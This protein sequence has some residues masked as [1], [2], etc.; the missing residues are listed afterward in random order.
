MTALPL[1]LLAMTFEEIDF[2]KQQAIRSSVE[3]LNNTNGK[4]GRKRKSA[5]IAR[6]T[7]GAVAA[8]MMMA[9]VV[10]NSGGGGDHLH[11]SSSAAAA[12]SSSSASVGGGMG[13]TTTSTTSELRTGRWTDEETEYCDALIVLFELGKLPIPDGIKLN[14]FLANM[15]K[16]KQSRLTKKMKN[17]R[18]STK[19][20]QRTTGHIADANEAMT[21]S[22]IETKFVASIKCPMERA[23]IRFHMQK[24]WREHFS[25]Y[26]V[27]V[28]QPL[29][30]NAW[31]SSVEELDRRASVQKDTERTVRR[32][33][34]MGH[35]LHFDATNCHSR[36]VYIEGGQ[37]QQQEPLKTTREDHNPMQ[38][39]AAPFIAKVLEIMK[40]HHFPFEHVDAWVPSFLQ[41]GGDQQGNGTGD[42][43]SNNNNSAAAPCRLCFAGCGTTKYKVQPGNQGAAAGMVKLGDDEEFHLL[44][45]GEYSQKFS[46][47]VGSG[48]PGRVYSSGVASWEQGIQNAPLAKFE[49][50][51]GASQWG[52]QT[53]LGIPIPSPSVGRIVVVFY[54]IHDRVRQL[55]LVQAIAEDLNKV[56]NRRR[57]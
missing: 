33:V 49:R 24:E 50:C 4:R 31:L 36:G 32:K 46:F 51:G 27:L 5:T 23:E 10:G 55:E 19:Q 25:N 38:H 2:A 12:L 7:G 1:H 14:E 18:L 29:D 22:K 15:L 20:Y 11:G 48:L 57:K 30:A 53:V 9:S 34:M 17:A 37:E 26:C 35:A 28:H 40:R 52:I 39:Y 56:S 47:D 41:M 43:S 8:T 3:Q 6:L 44:S 54:S 21:F 13:S 42:G 45:F 16:S